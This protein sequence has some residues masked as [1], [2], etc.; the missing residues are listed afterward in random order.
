[1]DIIVCE[2]YGVSIQ[3][4]IKESLRH[5]PNQQQPNQMW[6]LNVLGP[7]WDSGRGKVP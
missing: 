4:K 5:Y 3:A 2:Y 1:M 7:G 6:R